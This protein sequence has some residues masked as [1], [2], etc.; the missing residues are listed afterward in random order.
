MVDVQSFT[1]TG[2]EFKENVSINML[3]AS[4]VSITLGEQ[5]DAFNVHSAITAESFIQWRYGWL[6]QRQCILTVARCIWILNPYA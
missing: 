2:P 3:S 1:M 5:T 4:A 6:I